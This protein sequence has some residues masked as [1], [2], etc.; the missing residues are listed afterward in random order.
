MPKIVAA[1][2]NNPNSKLADF[3][4]VKM[5]DGISSL[6]IKKLNKIGQAKIPIKT[7]V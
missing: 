1:S 3:S 5:E 7:D 6:Q 2:P 4:K